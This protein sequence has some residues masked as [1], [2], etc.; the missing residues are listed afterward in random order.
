[1][2]KQRSEL[3]YALKAKPHKKVSATNNKVGVLH[4][5]CRCKGGT[6]YGRLHEGTGVAVQLQ[7]KL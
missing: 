5:V 1:M 7:T 6:H 3:M 4:M 2:K